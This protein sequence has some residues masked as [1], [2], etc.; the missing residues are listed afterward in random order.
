MGNTSSPDATPNRRYPASAQH[1]T[2]ET[3]PEERYS[4]TEHQPRM[5]ADGGTPIDW[6][7]QNPS[8][9]MKSLLDEAIDS[10]LTDK[11]TDMISN[12]ERQEGETGCVKM[13]MCKS[14]PFIWGMQKSLKKRIVGETDKEEDKKN[15]EGNEKA[16]N[17]RVFDVDSLYAHFPNLAEFREHGAKC[18]ELYSTYCN[19]TKL[20]RERFQ[21]RN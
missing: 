1:D 13:L 15:T 19:I 16:E 4:P 9:K 17:R 6:F 5:L 14:A 12:Y 21:E 2:A 18:E 8:K 3:G 20:R 10:S 11:I 7:L